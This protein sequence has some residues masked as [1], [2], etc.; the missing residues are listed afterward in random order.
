MSEPYKFVSEITRAA[1]PLGVTTTA[2]IKRDEVSALL[3]KMKKISAR[4]FSDW[5]GLY[6]GHCL[7]EYS[8]WNEKLILYK[9]RELQ[10]DI[11]QLTMLLVV[12]EPTTS[13]QE[14]RE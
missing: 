11:Q 3:M 7:G 5:A 2:H 13:Q 9:M 8:S 4:S 10:S 12:N 14:A 1:L 6:F